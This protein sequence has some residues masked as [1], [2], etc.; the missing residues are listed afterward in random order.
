MKRGFVEL[1]LRLL[2]FLGVTGSGKSLF[3]QLVLGLPAP[4]DSPSTPLAKSAVRTMSICQAAVGSGIEWKVVSP[5][6]M[7]DMVAEAIRERALVFD[8]P[9]PITGSQIHPS[10]LESPTHQLEPQLQPVLENESSQVQIH[11]QETSHPDIPQSSKATPTDEGSKQPQEHQA[12][13]RAFGF[14]EALKEIKIINSRLIKK[15]SNPSGANIQ[16]LMNVDFIY[17]LDSGGQPPFRDMLL[18]FVQQASAVVL[19]QKLNE[20][21]DR[22]PTIRYREEGGK[23]GKGYT[24]Q[25]TNEQILY[26]YIQAVQSHRSKVFVVGSHRDMMSGCEETIKTK[27]DELLESFLPVIKD[28]IVMYQVGDPDQLIFPVDSTSREPD[29]IATAEIFKKRILEECE[30]IKEKIPLPWFILE[31]VLQLLAQKMKV[32]VLSTQECFEAADEMFSMPHDGCEAAIKYLGKLNIMFYRPKILPGI[33]FVNAQVILDKIT[34]LVRCN[35]ALRTDDTDEQ[36]VPSCMHGGP[37]FDFRDLGLINAKLLG[38]A[39][40]SHY[41]DGVFTP[42]DLLKLFEGL[43]IA[44][45]LSEEKYFMPSLL[46]DLSDEHIANYRLKSSGAEKPAPLIIHYSKMWVPVGVIPSLVVYLQNKCR[47]KVSEKKNGKP[48][49][50]YHNCIQFRLPCGKPGSVFL[51]DSTKYLEIHVTSNLKVDPDLL[52]IKKDIVTG[53]TQVH[54]SL[55]Y[56]LAKAEFG[57]FCSGECGNKEPHLA[58]L[59]DK[60]E[61]WT[62]SEDDEIGDS[63]D[64]PRQ[65]VWKL[66]DHDE[67]EFTNTI[68]ESLVLNLG[69]YAWPLILPHHLPTFHL[70]QFSPPPSPSSP[71]QLLL[72]PLP[73][74]L[75]LLP[76]PL[77][78]SP[79]TLSPHH[80]VCAC[81]SCVGG[82]QLEIWLFLSPYSRCLSLFFLSHL[83][84]LSHFW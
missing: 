3:Q 32:T 77:L 65:E 21:L 45:K 20:K 39:F 54:K 42:T 1:T 60:K 24:S 14:S 46:P 56:E 70:L 49:C 71:P 47:W 5:Q 38:K 79:L 82:H 34:E 26:Q 40:P 18:H 30:G 43:L 7:M 75:S 78:V 61:I 41:R 16:K 59:D 2:I 17:L 33:V 6:K 48:S 63:L 36:K 31:Q 67:G 12:T 9:L 81:S 53:L 19:M 68:C 29:D 64:P 69:M 10:I 66:D 37:G 76:P 27:N 57:F 83:L 13:S 80:L 50:L 74:P 11:P 28:H 84:H 25:L 4:E 23:V 44:G 52:R 72:P 55:N 8:L 51:I 58:T 22:K 15:L 62:C 73:L 35:H